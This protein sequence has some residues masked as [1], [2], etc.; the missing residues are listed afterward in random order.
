MERKTGAKNVNGKPRI[1]SIDPL[2]AMPGGEVRISGSGL[3]PHEMRRPQVRF[4]DVEGSVI[5]GYEQFIVARV[6]EGA[7]TSEVVVATNG[8]KSNPREVKIAVPR[9]EERRVGKEC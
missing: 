8:N 3:R 6:P 9:S 4:G 7:A 5:I 1:D 2:C